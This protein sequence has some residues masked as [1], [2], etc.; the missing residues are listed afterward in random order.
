[1]SPAWV[2][3][4][5]RNLPVS[6]ATMAELRGGQEFRGWDESR[7]QYAATVDAIRALTHV[8]I[9]AHTDKNAKKPKLPEPWPI[10]DR[11]VR[12]ER[13]KTG[14]FAQMAAAQM[15]AS[16]KLKKKDGA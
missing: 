1:M 14:V 13:S 6:S 9:L 3:A 15:A 2:M 7:Y 8:F 12:A 11:R 16:R 10:P 5:V 4:H